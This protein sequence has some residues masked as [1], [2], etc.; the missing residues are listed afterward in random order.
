MTT[1][2][3]SYFILLG[4]AF[5]WKR[6]LNC[7]AWLLTSSCAVPAADFGASKRLGP[8]GT[9]CESHHSLKGTPYFMAPEQMLQE[10]VGRKS[11]I[12]ALGGVALLMATGDPP[13]AACS[14]ANP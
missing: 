6:Q 2:L 5:A 14:L 3:S 13:W 11:D 10:N 4:S 1:F 12:W 8:D 7:L 9:V